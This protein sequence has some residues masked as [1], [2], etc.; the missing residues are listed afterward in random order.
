MQKFRSTIHQF[1][2]PPAVERRERTFCR[3]VLWDD[4]DNASP[5]VQTRMKSSSIWRWPEHH[6]RL[7]EDNK[8]LM[9]LNV[10][11]N[12]SRSQSMHNSGGTVPR[13]M[14]DSESFQSDFR[15]AHREAE[16]SSSKIFGDDFVAPNPVSEE[17]QSTVRPHWSDLNP[18]R[19]FR[20]TNTRFR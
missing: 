17:C 13:W 2:K 4:I 10:L 11:E 1:V 14:C 20:E 6:S 16:R 12:R 9:R 18:C 8:G 15:Y 5:A 19:E 7:I 3:I